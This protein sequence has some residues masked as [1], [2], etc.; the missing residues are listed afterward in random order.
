[1]KIEAN[2]FGHRDWGPRFPC[3]CKLDKVGPLP[4]DI[5][6]NEDLAFKVTF[7]LQEGK[8]LEHRRSIQS[9]YTVNF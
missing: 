1:M 7:K 8:V 5:D 2:I 4:I 3:L 6:E 9:P